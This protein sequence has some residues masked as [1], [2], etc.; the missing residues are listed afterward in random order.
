MEESKISEAEIKNLRALAIK[1]K[2]TRSRM[3]EYITSVARNGLSAEQQMELIK[4]GKK[5]EI[6]ALL[7]AYASDKATQKMSAAAQLY[8]YEKGEVG[9][10]AEIYQF[11]LEKVPFSDEFAKRLIEDHRFCSPIERF[12]V[13]QELSPEMQCYFL[14]YKLTDKAY[15]RTGLMVFKSIALYFNK[16]DFCE[17]AELYLLEKCL[18]PEP[19]RDSFMDSCYK[20]VREYFTCKKK[21]SLAGE[22]VLI[23]S[24]NHE[25]I[26]KYI[27][28]AEQ[29]LKAEDELLARGNREEVTAYFER[30]AAL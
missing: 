16:Y 3:Q 12:C 25:L 23:A 4:R 1:E 18:N 10:N 19:S 5:D 21:L 7:Q 22:N 29:G 14:E 20:L 24:G 26:L 30:Y 13:L 8:L 2:Q 27:K 28:I 9:D 15:H 11:L 6:L 17:K